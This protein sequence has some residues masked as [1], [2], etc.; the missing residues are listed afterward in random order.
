MEELKLKIEES[1]R[2][3]CYVRMSQ[4]DYARVQKMCE[5]TGE[6]MPEL[7]RKALLKR[8]DLEQPAMKPDDVHEIKVALNRLGGSIHQIA[9]HLNFGGRDGW[10]ISFNQ[11]TRA[12][13]DLRHMFIGNYAGR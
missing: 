8:K 5:A 3:V 2:P 4:E 9:K 13:A 7:F 1:T 12:V 10:N 11:F 6:S